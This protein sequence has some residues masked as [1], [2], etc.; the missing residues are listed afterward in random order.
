MLAKSYT[1]FSEPLKC[2]I[3]KDPIIMNSN[4]KFQADLTTT[5]SSTSFIKNV[6][7][8]ADAVGMDERTDKRTAKRTK[9]RM[10]DHVGQSIS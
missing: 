4:G 2:S 8:K 1:I 9:V 10:N 5:S 6:K 3:K 7:F